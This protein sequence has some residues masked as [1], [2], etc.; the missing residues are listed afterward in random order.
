MQIDLTLKNYRC[1]ADTHPV[2]ISLAPGLV[3]FVGVNNS[4]KSALL[5]FFYEFRNLFT[6][7]GAE[8]WSDNLLTGRPA[9]SYS[10][11]V[12][13]QAEPFTN[14]N[15]RDLRIRLDVRSETP[16]TESSGLPLASTLEMIIPRGTNTFTAQLML[17]NEP[18]NRESLRVRQNIL[19][20]SD[21][22]LA[23]VS[24]VVDACKALSN[25][26]YL[27][28]FRNAVN[29]G[30]S[31]DYF[32]MSVG[33]AFVAA[34]RIHKTGPTKRKSEATGRLTEDIRR[35]LGF[36]KLEINASH[37]GKTIQLFIN[38]KS[39]RLDE[40]GAGIAQFILVLANAAIKQPDY[41]LIDEPELNLH[42]S[43]QLDFLT[44][45]AS[46]AKRG[47]LYATHS[48]GLARAASDRIYSVIR[49]ESGQ[50]EVHP[51]EGT[52]RLAEFLGSL[53]YAGYAQLGFEKLLLVEGPT[54][55]LTVQQ[56]LRIYRK[57]HKVVLLPLG[58]RSLINSQCGSQLAEV[59]RI[60]PDVSALID[61]ER[62]EAAAEIEAPI[63]G[64]VNVCQELGITCHLTERR[65]IENYL[66]E[67]AV[68]KVKGEGYR[69][70]EPYERLQDVS[71]CWSK[72][73]NWRIARE[74]CSHDLEG[75]DVGRFLHG[76]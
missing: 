28:A 16:V 68:Q 24:L 33:E 39:Y 46:Y 70:L 38:E 75:T 36:E 71:P 18:R 29:A 51:Y 45:L 76:L 50:S 2:T 20:G 74:M 59:K 26:L 15:S 9:F 10:P 32:D 58:G 72:G 64:F 49:N 41:V 13:D 52:P 5:R 3:S 65:A 54:D 53:S 7:F 61:S 57:D 62:A 44:T 6:R 56:F 34:W 35:I 30:A 63:A 25:T 47:I 22:R 40:V 55:V 27:P 67:T 4:G 60:C 21:G 11:S 14:T 66:V 1:F 48:Y 42:P 37:D 31:S 23:D 17:A 73:E 43:L 69:A 19:L 8:T 12:Q